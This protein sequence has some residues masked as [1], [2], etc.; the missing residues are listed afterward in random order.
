MAHVIVATDDV[1]KCLQCSVKRKDYTYCIKNISFG[2][3]NPET[4]TLKYD[5]HLWW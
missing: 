2:E 3:K 1:E 5:S 4:N